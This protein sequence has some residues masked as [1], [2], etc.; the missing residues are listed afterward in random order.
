MEALGREGSVDV[1]AHGH[2]MCGRT[3]Q[4]Q[5]RDPRSPTCAWPTPTAPAALF[6]SHV[7]AI[8]APAR[9]RSNLRRAATM[10]DLEP[11]GCSL[12]KP[13]FF[14]VDV[15]SGAAMDYTV[16]ATLI[17][18]PDMDEFDVA[19]WTVPS[20]QAS[21]YAGD[22]ASP[23]ASTPS[24]VYS[25]MS[26]SSTASSDDGNRTVGLGFQHTSTSFGHTDIDMFT[27]KLSTLPA[28]DRSPCTFGD[29]AHYAGSTPA[30]TPFVV[31][32]P[33]RLAPPSDTVFNPVILERT[34]AHHHAGLHGSAS[35][36]GVASHTYGNS[37]NWSTS[38]AT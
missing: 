23:S 4:E 35:F 19:A 25:P 21:L 11:G 15:L 2:P 13:S 27:G 8:C 36:S 5:G 28:F 16:E 37:V 30:Q 32:M 1:A 20:I 31:N 18:E 33:S 7:A 34:L 38:C 29:I 9:G 10:P 6:T 3:L 14:P 24:L 22:F 12:N 26:T 17:A